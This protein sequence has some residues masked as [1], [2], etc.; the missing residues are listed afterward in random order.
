M[1]WEWL[2]LKLGIK[3]KV[4]ITKREPTPTPK[5]NR[6]RGRRTFEQIISTL[7]TVQKDLSNLNK[8]KEGQLNRL[9]EEKKRIAMLMEEAESEKAKANVSIDNINKI[10]TEKIL[11][12]KV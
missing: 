8:E 4:V 10:F 12:E 11:T 3:P 6:T 9:D 5:E 2:K 7:S 1:T